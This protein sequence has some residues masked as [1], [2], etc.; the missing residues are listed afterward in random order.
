MDAF[1]K[2]ASAK[3]KDKEGSALYTRLYM[4]AS[5]CGTCD[6]K[7]NLF[8]DTQVSWPEMKKGFDDLMRLYPHSAWNLNKYASFACQA[9][10]KETFLSVRFRIGKN[11]VSEAWR[12]NYSF[13]LCDH[14][15]PTQPL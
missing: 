4:S 2:E 6:Q 11:V 12:P 10:D 8:R 7:F 5:G 14:Q 1:I 15:F 13:D 3:A 9:G